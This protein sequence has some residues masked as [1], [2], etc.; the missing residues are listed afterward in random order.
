VQLK[1]ARPPSIRTYRNFDLRLA[2]GDNNLMLVEVLDAPAGE[3]MGSTPIP[4]TTRLPKDSL[5]SLGIEL[6]QA[7]MP[8]DVRL[9]FEAS[10]GMLRQGQEGLRIRLRIHG[11]TLSQI[12]WEAARI[13][14]ESVAAIPA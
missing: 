6:G 2:E 9:C 12:P 1:Q 5:G 7:L 3:A 10:R 8:A 14:E 4:R 11:Q 13:G